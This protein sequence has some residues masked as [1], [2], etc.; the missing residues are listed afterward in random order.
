M[1]MVVVVRVAALSQGAPRQ[2]RLTIHRLDARKIERNG[3]KRGEHAHI[4][5]H[6]HVI[7][8]M[9]VTVRGDITRDGDME[10]GSSVDNCL[11]VFCDLVVE[12]LNGLIVIRRDRVLGTDGD[13]PPAADALVVV[14]LA[15]FVRDDGRAVGTDLRALAAADAKLRIHGGFPLC[16]HFH[17]T[18]A[19]AAAH[20][21]VL[22]RAAEARLLVA[23]EVRQ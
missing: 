5:H 11:C 9:A 21:E 22:E 10:A 4:R 3:V 13:A 6:R 17:L 12:H 16:V 20:A 19:R 2:D 7:L 18:R 14:D 1:Q 23:L 8:L 15:L